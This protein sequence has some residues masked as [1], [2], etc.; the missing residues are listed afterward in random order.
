MLGFVPK[1]LNEFVLQVLSNEGER[2]HAAEVLGG[3]FKSR[4]DATAFFQPADEPFHN[5]ASPVGFFVELNGT[6]RGVLILFG[7]NH[8]LNSKLEQVFIDPVSAVSLIAAEGK[9]P[10]DALAIFVEQIVVG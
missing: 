6:S 5:V 1:V 10:S 9:R 3:L 8:G 7:R 4:K 2:D